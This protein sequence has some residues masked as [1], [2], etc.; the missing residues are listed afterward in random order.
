MNELLKKSVLIKGPG[1][2]GTHLLINWFSLH[3]DH[4][5]FDVSR[6][7]GFAPGSDDLPIANYQAYTAADEESRQFPIIFE[8]HHLDQ[9]RYMPSNPKDWVLIHLSRKNMFEQIMSFAVAIHLNKWV[10][11][12][13][14]DT[15][16]HPKPF[17]V[18][19]SYMLEQR[20]EILRREQLISE[21]DASQFYKSYRFYY[22]DLLENQ[23]DDILGSFKTQ[24]IS[25]KQDMTVKSPYTYKE[26]VE[27]WK[28]LKEVWDLL[29]Y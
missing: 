21:I 20:K 5:I 29:K 17:K 26:L 25:K 9:S 6:F 18:S 7:P 27:N 10:F 15:I 23:H 28:E 3:T 19:I 22:E 12:P 13:D 2:C 11:W 24:N 1:R 4:T 16:K 8:C 14:D